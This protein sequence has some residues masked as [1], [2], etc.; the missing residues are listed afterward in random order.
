MV[1]LT[2]PAGRYHGASAPRRSIRDASKAWNVLRGSLKRDLGTLPY[3]R[4]LELTQRGVAHL[5]VVVRVDSLDT[6]WRLRTIV[7]KAAAGAGFGFVSQVDL[8]KRQGDV[9]RYVTKAE[10]TGAASAAAGYATKGIDGRVPKWTRRASWSRDWSEWTRPT[11]IAGFSW[12]V[13]PLDAAGLSD[14]F[15]ASDMVV[16]DPGSLRVRALPAMPAGGLPC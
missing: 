15:A 12:A 9:A 6:F 13:R 8:A 3:F 5:H 2:L 7:R 11:P 1:T 4:G 14:F 10:G 16:V